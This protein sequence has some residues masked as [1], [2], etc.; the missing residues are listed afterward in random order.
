MWRCSELSWFTVIPIMKTPCDQ[1]IVSGFYHN[2]IFYHTSM[3]GF[4][5]LANTALLS[6]E[7][8]YY[9]TVMKL[10]VHMADNSTGKGIKP[11]Y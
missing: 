8:V 3:A 11:S 10:E 1:L 2:L 4:V 5:I 6:K 7:L 9:H